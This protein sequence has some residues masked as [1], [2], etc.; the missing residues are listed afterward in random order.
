MLHQYSNS[1]LGAVICAVLIALPAFGGVSCNSK[2]VSK[3]SVAQVFGQL[4]RMNARIDSLVQLHS[5]ESLKEA[6]EEKYKY[7]AKHMGRA[8]SETKKALSAQ[9]DTALA[10]CFL[11]L[12][13]SYGVGGPESLDETLTDIYIENHEI[14]EAAYLRLSTQEQEI[15][16]E[17]LLMI[18]ALEP[19]MFEDSAKVREAQDRIRDFFLK[20]RLEGK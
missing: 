17:H 10:I 16:S 11:K 5:G 8:L 2:E 15:V 4:I 3:D 18:E 6:K 1:K 12:I 7:E 20:L 9:N 19:D 14:I 13:E